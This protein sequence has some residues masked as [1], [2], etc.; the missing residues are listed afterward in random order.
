MQRE[1]DPR[2]GGLCSDC[3]SP[4]KVSFRHR[5]V[6][7]LTIWELDGTAFVYA[8]DPMEAG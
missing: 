4:L 5:L 8:S 1:A 2:N 7:R 3:A 6:T